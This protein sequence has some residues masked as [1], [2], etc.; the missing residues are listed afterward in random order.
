MQLPCLVF[1]IKGSSCEFIHVSGPAS[2]TLLRC[3]LR[4]RCAEAEELDE[5][6]ILMDAALP[7]VRVSV[8]KP[9]PARQQAGDQQ[10]PGP[11]Q[12]AVPP[13]VA[14][15]LHRLSFEEGFQEAPTT[16]ALAAAAPAAPPP[17]ASAAAAA[18]LVGPAEV[19]VQEAVSDVMSKASTALSRF[20]QL[21][22]SLLQHDGLQQKLASRLSSL[23]ATPVATPAGAPLLEPAAAAQHEPSASKGRPGAATLP[24]GSGT[25]AL[26]T[27]GRMLTGGLPSQPSGSL[28]VQ[29]PAASSMAEQP[30]ALP[31][32]D[33]AAAGGGGGAGGQ[34]GTRQEQAAGEVVVSER[35]FSDGR[36]ERVFASGARLQ[37]FP[38]GSTK[39]QW[40]TGRCDTRFANGDVKRAWPDGE[41][42]GDCEH[43][44][45][46][47]ASGRQWL[48]CSL[49]AGTVDSCP[50]LATILHVSW[51]ALRLSMHLICRCGCWCGPCRACGVLL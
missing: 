15:A 7:A 21:R 43:V 37:Q 42:H 50:A 6:T 4:R 5:D 10:R 36:V 14:T 13:V 24:A 23:Q 2:Q 3:V 51:P 47:P 1:N 38:N 11:Q 12:G 39:Q 22:E 30:P 25:D 35:Q 44:H 41:L 20:N 48:P 9:Q 26:R 46:A 18:P 16:A 8:H 34:A 45:T 33:T 31:P 29:L 40:P 28:A 17:A 19:S 49:A 27:L 32:E